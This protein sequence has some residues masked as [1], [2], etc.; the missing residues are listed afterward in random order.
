LPVTAG[1]AAARRGIGRGFAHGDPARRQRG[2]AA[3]ANPD[4]NINP[5]GRGLAE[6]VDQV[7]RLTALLRPTRLLPGGPDHH[8]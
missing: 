6:G 2:T 7:K 8:S 3:A 4:G 1:R 5:I